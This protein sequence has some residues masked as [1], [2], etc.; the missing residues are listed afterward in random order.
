MKLN[1]LLKNFISVIL[2]L[3]IVGG[4]FSVI[5]LP[6]E[7]PNTISLSQLV[8]DINQDKVKKITVSG[9][10]VKVTYTDNKTA[11]SMKETNSVLPDLLTNLGADKEKLKKIEI[12][13]SV[14]QES[15][16]SW[17]LPALIYGILPLVFIGFFLWT[18]MKQAR[19]GAVQVFDFTK[20]KARIFGAEGHGKQ[21]I[22]FKDVAGLKEAKEELIEIVDFL[23]FPK[24]YLAMGAKIPR[25]VL[26]LGPAGVG[27]TLLAR[28]VA[29]EANVPFFSISGS[30]FVEMFVG[31]GSARVR[32]LF[33]T[34]KKAS[35]SII[36]IDELDAIGRHRGA[37]IGG[38][39]DEREQTLN[40]I[41][42]EMDGFEKE[43]GVIVMA[44]TNRGDIL[45]PA[46]LR[47]GRFDRKI[48]LDPPDVH[49][50][51]EILKIHSK[52][53][54]LA[55]NINFKEIAER[56]PGFS[57]ADLANV[58]NEAALLAARQNKTQVFQ[59]DFLEAIEKVLLGPERKSH[60]LSKKEKEIAAYHEAGHALVS[61]S[62]PGTEP[63]R[64]ISIISRGMAGGYTLQ[65]PSESNKMRT[66]TQFLAEIATLLGGMSAER[67]IFGEMTTGASNDLVKAS[68]LARRIVKEYGMS[69]LGPISFG[70][71][72]EM[73]FLGREISE[74]R[75][76]SEVVAEKI[77]REIETIIRGAEKKAA[78][79][80]ARKKD[81]LEK[82]AKTLIEKETIER[83][84]FEKIIGNG[85]KK[86]GKK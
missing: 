33:S 49:D 29:G 9:D 59:T 78:E 61:S 77:D 32:D 16:W 10:S 24:K 68:E 19:S 85:K 21:K 28:A 42:V 73:V 63:V 38:G 84:E 66:K 81:L 52:E 39:H 57:G 1:P 51:E 86:N 31:V 58:A 26:L 55:E 18:I 8:S 30:E 69:S 4:I 12:E 43:S 37:G 70:D 23:K 44:A 53:K 13:A 46:L 75:N 80:V 6:T 71:K 17:L 74:Q 82:I 67:L 64:K 20:A 50:R 14:K 36:F 11:E 48:V 5:Y 62:I 45:D 7:Q 56:T 3:L 41:L 47:P 72:D 35:P 83:E 79:I 34:A 2:I 65:V 27:K 54:P 40:M 15:V 76:Y 25:G 22:T 60:L